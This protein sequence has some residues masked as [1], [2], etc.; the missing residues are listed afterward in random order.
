MR[1]FFKTISI[2]Q[3]L[4]PVFRSRKSLKEAWEW[5]LPK[6]ALPWMPVTTMK[7]LRVSPVA[8]REF[9]GPEMVPDLLPVRDPIC[10]WTLIQNTEAGSVVPQA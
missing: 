5:P 9:P 3:L 6:P 8:N 10:L 1:K 7:P 4:I 2:L